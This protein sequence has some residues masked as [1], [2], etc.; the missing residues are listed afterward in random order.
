[1]VQSASL[2]SSV[3]PLP[4]FSLLFWCLLLQHS[5][6]QDQPPSNPLI[7][8][9]LQSGLEAKKTKAWS[10]QKEAQWPS[11]A[12]SFHCLMSPRKLKSSGST[13]LSKLALASSA[14]CMGPSDSFAVNILG[15]RTPTQRVNAKLAKCNFNARVLVPIKV[16]WQSK[17]VKAP[18][19]SPE[20][21]TLP[22]QSGCGKSQVG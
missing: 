3:P 4:I 5:R 20:L 18:R 12:V 13:L 17:Q 6:I 9:S 8:K 21:K 10:N 19:S 2:I 14:S 11:I 1:M 15:N 22:L 7:G 16:I